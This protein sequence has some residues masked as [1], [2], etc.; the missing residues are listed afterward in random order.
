M[1]VVMYVI[2]SNTYF[3][4]IVD[5]TRSAASVGPRKQIRNKDRKTCKTHTRSPARRCS[6]ILFECTLREHFD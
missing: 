1:N 2:Q 4:V 6:R 5:T 3:N